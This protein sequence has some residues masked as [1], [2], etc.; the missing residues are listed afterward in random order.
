MAT[1]DMQRA[2]C[3]AMRI[4]SRLSQLCRGTRAHCRCLCSEWSQEHRLVVRLMHEKMNKR[5]TTLVNR[6]NSD[7][8]DFA[9]ALHVKVNH[10]LF[11]GARLHSRL[12]FQT[13]RCF[14]VSHWG[15]STS[16]STT[17][18]KRLHTVQQSVCG[19]SHFRHQSS[20]QAT[21]SPQFV[22]IRTIQA[23]LLQLH[24]RPAQ[25]EFQSVFT[26]E[27][28]KHL[29]TFATVAAG[30]GEA[31]AQAKVQAGRQV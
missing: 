5:F 26:S 1:N 19:P 27:V 9:V 17:F 30:G 29:H 23:V 24:A 16:T 25:T 31:Q 11:T 18:T 12:P 28:S 21:L 7:S 4:C 14:L 8:T 3:S 22:R 2:L 10:M 20:Q 15:S 13:F 6:S